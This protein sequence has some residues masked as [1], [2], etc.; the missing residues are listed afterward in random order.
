MKFHKYHGRQ[1]QQDADLLFER[2]VVFSTYATLASE[3]DRGMGILNSVE[4]FRIV[5]DEGEEQY[6]AEYLAA[7]ER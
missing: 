2:D 4:W 7:L 5:L 1:R 6:H 3:P